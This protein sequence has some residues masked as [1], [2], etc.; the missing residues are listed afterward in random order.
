MSILRKQNL[1]ISILM[2]FIIASFGV[3]YAFWASSVEGSSSIGE[4]VLEIGTWMPNDF[5]GVTE[6]GEGDMIK[7]NEIGTI[8]YPLSGKYIQMSDINWNNLAFTPIGLTSSSAFTGEYHGNGFSISN[9]NINLTHT[10]TGTTSYAGLFYRNSGLISRVSLINASVQLTK[11]ATGIG[12]D[13]LRLGAIAG[14]NTG[15]IVYSYSSGTVSGTMTRSSSSNNETI[16]TYV[17]AGGIAGTNSGNIH[18]SYSNSTISAI[19]NASPANNN[20]FANAFGYAGGLVGRNESAGSILN[21]YAIGNV[22]AE[23]KAVNTG[24][25]PNQ[26]EA[27][28]YA[29]GLVGHNNSGSVSYS[30]ATGT[31]QAR[32]Q[33]SGT[34]VAFRYFGYINGLGTSNSSFRLDTQSI[35]GFVITPSA[36]GS[37]VQNTADSTVTST[38]QAN[39]RSEAYITSNLLWNA[40]EWNFDLTYYPRLKK[41]KY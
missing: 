31:V 12:T 32:T 33:A 22:T 28:A 11:S 18:N 4:G 25:R 39:L 15:S 3:T 7:L 37:S 9:I 41:N 38:T 29:G 21:T 19:S 8:A 16:N 5:F 10:N 35:S 17:F 34:G 40:D 13:D 20:S 27:R 36:T 26:S 1:I 30:F 24:N 6:D 14:E 2:L 23:A